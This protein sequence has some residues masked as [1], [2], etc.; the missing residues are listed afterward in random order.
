M[1]G[2]PDAELNPDFGDV[3]RTVT[4]NCNNRGMAHFSDSFQV[5]SQPPVPQVVFVSSAWALMDVPSAQADSALARVRDELLERGWKVTEHKNIHNR[6]IRL[7]AQPSGSS[8]T[9]DI[10]THSAGK[11]TV[12][13]HSECTR[14]PSGTPL[15][16]QGS[17]RLPA[18]KLPTQLRG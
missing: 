13:A 5:Q 6:V 11:L 17:P 2:L 8:D 14:Y 4:E 7:R 15:D 1:L 10:D 18:Q 12:S 3:G 9:V 16:G